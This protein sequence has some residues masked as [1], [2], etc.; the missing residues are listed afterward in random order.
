MKKASLIFLFNFLF[1]SSIHAV[2]VD[3]CFVA[4]TSLQSVQSHLQTVLS[5]RDEVL[6]NSSSHCLNVVMKNELKEE[7][8]RKWIS[9]KYQIISSSGYSNTGIAPRVS[10]QQHCRLEM[11]RV[12][13]ADI[14]TQGGRLSQNSKA[15]E[16]NF[17]H[18]GSQKSSILLSIGRPGSLRVDDDYLNVICK[19]QNSSRVF[20]DISLTGIKSSVSTSVTLERGESLN[21]ASVVEGLNDRFKELSL[22]NGVSIEKTKGQKQFQYYLRVKD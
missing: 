4:T 12:T 2:V 10:E 15:Y 21:L 14:K 1:L 17:R 22:K 20:L 13:T 18:S 5:P 19:S 3:Y 9:R 16:R 7:L 11:E 8:Y 6:I